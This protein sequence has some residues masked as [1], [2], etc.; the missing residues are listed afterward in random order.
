MHRSCTAARTNPARTAPACTILHAHIVRAQVRHA[1]MPHAELLCTKAL[2]AWIP[3]VQSCI[4]RICM[5]GSCTEM[6][7]AQTCVHKSC[8]CKSRV[9]GSCMHGSRMHRFYV[10]RS[11]MHKPHIWRCSL[12][13]PCMHSSCTHSPCMQKIFQAHPLETSCPGWEE[14]CSHL[15]QHLQPSSLC[16]PPGPACAD[17]HQRPP[18]L[19]KAPNLTPF[20]L[21]IWEVALEAAVEPGCTWWG[22]RLV[23]GAAR[24]RA[25][26]WE[27]FPFYL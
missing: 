14:L 22:G 16:N 12:Q 25:R 8:T 1:E 23:P 21:N 11:C 18:W 17:G 15:L 5:H 24:G 20:H 4:H 10:H 13:R 7:C 27:L 26:H 9:H 6:L 2:R 19:R 3:W